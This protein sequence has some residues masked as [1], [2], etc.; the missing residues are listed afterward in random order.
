MAYLDENGLEY[1][2]S[3]L[4]TEGKAKNADH[5]TTAGTASSCSG[6][7][8]TAT[9]ATQLANS[10]NIK[11]TGDA[12]GSASF[13]GTA[14][15]SITVTIAD[16]SHNHVISNVDGLQAALDGKAPSSHGNHVPATQTAN[17]AV[18]LR[19]DNSWQ[20]VTPGNIGA[21]TKAEVDAKVVAITNDA[22]DSI[23][24]ASIVGSGEVDF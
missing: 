22:I 18:F 8:A 2:L 21:Y 20:T 17:N 10:R 23:C 13:N 11:L 7:A 6:N 3:K 5:A 16:D 9:K 12:S 24:G 14:D 15:A 1:V 19:N 4:A